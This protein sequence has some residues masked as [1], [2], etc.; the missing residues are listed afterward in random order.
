MAIC[1]RCSVEL[2][3]EP[4]C[5]RCG[6]EQ[7]PHDVKKTDRSIRSLLWA[8][9]LVI[10][11][12]LLSNAI[13]MPRG[14]RWSLGWDIAFLA[15]VGI[16]ALVH[17]NKLG[18]ALSWKAMAPRDLLITLLFQSMLTCAVLF[19][20]NWMAHQG[21]NFNDSC[22]VYRESGHPY[23]FALLSIAVFPALTEELAFRGILFAQ[24]E[25]LTTRNASILVT[26]F[27]FAWTHFSFLSLVWLVPAGLYFGWMRARYNTIWYGVLCHFAH[28][29]TVVF[30]DM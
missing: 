15:L 14:V 29:A 24:L 25:R 21:V 11:Y 16:I 19:I 23:L 3:S 2:A 17:R 22:A 8:L 30:V 20:A 4:F 5:P 10:G 1:V 12:V 27:L 9:G 18:D 26:G 7:R 28:N 13:D 6:V